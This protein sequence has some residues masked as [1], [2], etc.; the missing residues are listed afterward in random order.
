MVERNLSD[1]YR[2][3]HRIGQG[4][5]AVVYSGID[6]VLRRR[7]AIKVLRE[8]LAAD[9]DFVQRFYIE[10]QHAAKLS[11]P[12]IVNIYDVGREGE[13]YFIVM[14]LVDG[15][16]LGEMI[17]KDGAL[18]E[19]V[20]IDFAAQIC[21]GLAYAHRMGLMHRDVK[22][23]NILI[24]KDD[25]VKLSDFGIA[26]AVTTQTVTITA[27]GMVMG[28]VFYISPEQAQGLDLQENSDLYSVG[29]VLYQMLSGKLPYTGESP[30]TV[31]LKHVSSPVPSLDAEDLSISPALVAIVRKLMQKDPR[32][33]YQSAVEVAKALR[34]AREQPLLATAHD[35]RTTREQSRYPRTIPNPKPRPSRL[36][37]H[38][39]EA[40]A[41]EHE[42]LEHHERPPR[43]SGLYIVALFVLLLAIAGGYVF[44]NRSNLFGGPVTYA[45]TNL[46]GETA[47]EA[48]KKLDATGL[49]WN[50]VEV[51]S[52]EVAQN[53]V[54]KQDPAPSLHVPAQT[55]VQL[56]VSNGLPTVDLI[57]VRQYSSDDAQRY[58]RNA[59]L[60]P[61]ITEVF[62]KSPRGTVLSEQPAPGATV[63]IHSAVALVVSKGLKPVYVP[64]VVSLM[65]DDA[66]RAVDGRNLKFVVSERDPSDE[67]AA[68]V[69]TSQNPLPGTALDPGSTISVVVSSGAP[70]IEVPD[71][72]GRLADEAIGVLQTA[73]LQSSVEYLVD[74][75]AAAGTVVK[76][77]PEKPTTLTKGSTVNLD[78]GVPG[79]IPSV[80]GRSPGD[81][82]TLLEDYGYKV[83]N[84][85]Y[86]QE[87]ADGTVARTEPSEGT[88][89]RPGET[90][91]L[92]V[93]GTSGSP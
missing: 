86:V 72:E 53:R 79:T 48:E 29:I 37:D 12:N 67:I 87:G 85:A 32:D 30:V 82:T 75:S 81:A 57:D 15:T 68:G 51:P 69:V 77:D 71:V 35:A 49:R 60:S 66:Q 44:A 70:Q 64:D 2:L 54:V 46:T 27:P 43:R 62:D 20:A 3:E 40:S 24:T 88:S 41:A 61:K 83:G 84:T 33:R 11:H 39:A 56:Y 28:S 65:V 31:A 73:G 26:R 50:V 10:A 58:L 80:G 59:K 4:G 7:V 63:R 22:P 14:E 36:P 18:P 25:V 92:Y 23:A 91:M 38:R 13:N 19:P 74:G 16:T 76:Q 78:V 9:V 21:S 52:E 1:R 93:N 42:V 5:M 47:D 17:E 89:L 45:L 6:T 55:V 90:V 8:H 34:E